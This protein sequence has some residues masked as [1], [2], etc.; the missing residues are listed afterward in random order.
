MIAQV[1]PYRMG[2]LRDGMLVYP[3]S[4]SPLRLQ[5][6]YLLSPA[7]TIGCTGRF[8]TALGPS[9]TSGNSSAFFVIRFVKA[10]AIE[11][12]AYSSTDELF[13][14]TTAFRTYSNGCV[15]HSL[16]LLKSMATGFTKIFVCRHLDLFL[17]HNL[18]INY[19]HLLEKPKN[20][21]QPLLQ[22]L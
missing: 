21:V 2:H 1:I 3:F 12:H 8:I 17:S 4:C 15:F 10:A 11:Y 14:C 9:T 19:S 5:G 7:F 6:R 18:L 16:E 13:H 22:F 20:V